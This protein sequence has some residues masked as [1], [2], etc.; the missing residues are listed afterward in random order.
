[1]GMSI[2]NGFAA[3]TVNNVAVTIDA[4]PAALVYAAFDQITVQV[5]YE[6]TLAAARAVSV[7]NNGAIALG[8]V[9]VAATAPGIFSLNGSG[10]GQAAALTFSMGSGLYSING[11]SSP[12]HV[13]DIVV[14]YLTGE[15]TYAG[16]S[17][18]VPDG[19]IVPVTLV[20]LPQVFPLPA[21]TIGGAAATVQYAGPMVGGILGVL[22]IN[23]VVPL[24]VT[25]GNAVPVSVA[26]GGA[27]SQP[28]VTVAVK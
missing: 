25:T 19:Y 5:P 12:A 18:P 22:Q 13:G 10:T 20:P 16:N 28:G 17:I 23:A 24:G 11:Q 9:D 21:V 3:T 26:I 8:Q 2:V 7:T 1:V 6:V 4:L 14:L 27:T 15:G